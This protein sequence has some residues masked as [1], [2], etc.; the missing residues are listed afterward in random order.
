MTYDWKTT[1][2]DFNE[3]TEER[4]SEVWEEEPGED[5]SPLGLGALQDEDEPEEG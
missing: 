4:G 5:V 3:E 1:E 2:P